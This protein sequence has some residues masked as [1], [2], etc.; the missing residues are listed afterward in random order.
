MSFGLAANGLQWDAGAI[1]NAEWTGV[2]LRDVLLDSGL[3]VNDLPPHAKHAQFYGAEGYGASI[4]MPKACDARG[5]TLL[6]FAMNGQ[7][8]PPD[9]GAPVRALGM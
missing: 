4:P 6:A 8:L 2:R 1:S 9:H 5:D 3:D 7:D